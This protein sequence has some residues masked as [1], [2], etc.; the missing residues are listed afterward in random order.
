MK[1]VTFYLGP[2]IGLATRTLVVRRMMKAGDDSTPAAAHN[3]DAGGSATNVTVALDDGQIW[4]AT[5]TDVKSTGEELPPQ[6]IQFNTGTLQHLGPRASSPSGSEF[7][8]YT[9]EDL[10]SSS[11][12]SSQSSSSSSS[13]SSVS[14]QSSS[15]VSSQSSSSSSDSSSSSSDSSSS[16]VSSSSSSS[17]SSSSSSSSSVSSSSSS[18]SI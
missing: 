4:Q 3:A 14:S 2:A 18:Q 7:R 8:I 13:S 9:M 10:S 16:S 12:S 11:S 5:L 6:V 15:S 1:N 17:D